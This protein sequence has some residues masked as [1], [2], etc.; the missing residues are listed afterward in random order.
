MTCF[1]SGNI[2]SVGPAVRIMKDDADDP[3]TTPDS[4][5]G[6]FLFNSRYQ[7]LGYIQKILKL[8][9]DQ[10]TYPGNTADYYLPSGSTLSNCKLHVQNRR[11]GGTQYQTYFF[12]ESYFD[13]DFD[14][15]PLVEVRFGYNGTY[16]GPKIDITAF[17]GA[18]TADS[19]GGWDSY[20]A[21]IGTGRFAF[22]VRL[23]D[24]SGSKANEAIVAMFN[25]PLY[26]DALPDYSGSPVSW[27]ETILF[28]D[29]DGGTARIS[30]PGYDVTETDPN[31]YIM[32]EAKVPAKLMASG[33]LSLA[34]DAVGTIT[35]AFTLPDATYLD[36]HVRRQ[37]R[38]DLWHPPYMANASTQSLKFTYTISGNTVTITNTSDAA[39]VIRYG[40][41]ADSDQAP[42]TGG[43]KVLVVD[44][45][46]T[47]DYVQIKKPGSS[48]SAPNLNDIMIDTRLA[49]YPILAEGY[50]AWPGGFP[51]AVVAPNR[52]KGE[53]VATI[54]FDNPD[55]LLVMCKL[56]NVFS[57]VTGSTPNQ[58]T[59]VWG[60]HT[61]MAGSG[62]TWDG[63]ATSMS[64]WADISP[65]SVDIYSGGDNAYAFESDGGTGW[66]GITW[67]SKN[68]GTRYYI[69]GIPQSL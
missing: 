57:R 66:K 26:D 20:I 31:R 41:F 14:F 44:N 68:Q 37:S 49:Y 23:D 52:F 36:F 46:G 4:D 40:L 54:S 2:P 15:V 24:S 63:R 1:F 13:D 5:T 29:E 58:P 9:I 7:K 60:R 30:L 45:D 16:Y 53:R 56:G 69:F 34:K 17:L 39:I 27:Q 59:A 43:S 47:R 62:T 67:V 42:T 38:S 12:Y 28:T 32:H 64:T 22:T 33:E 35:S 8:T 55:N 51:T 6:K 48:D 21:R 3:V 25:L 11:S 19:L 65:T 50:L 61:L 10:V 18:G